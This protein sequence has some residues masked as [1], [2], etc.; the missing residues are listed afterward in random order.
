M[1]VWGLRFRGFRAM[2][3]NSVRGSER[4]SIQL[5]V[6]HDMCSEGARASACG[7]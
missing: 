2:P 6:L 1:Q 3:G 4:S 7:L 5:G